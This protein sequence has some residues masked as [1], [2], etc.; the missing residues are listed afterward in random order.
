M[1]PNK[2]AA[3]VR[4]AGPYFKRRKIS[5][6]CVLVPN[7]LYAVVLHRMTEHDLMRP[8]FVLP[9]NMQ[10][11]RQLFREMGAICLFIET[12]VNVGVRLSACIS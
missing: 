11:K 6:R 1:I 8:D 3:I 7:R 2:S 12:A 4:T 10:A 9:A 5:Y